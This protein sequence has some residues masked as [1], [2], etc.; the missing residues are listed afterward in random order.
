MRRRLYATGPSSLRGAVGICGAYI[1]SAALVELFSLFVTKRMLQIDIF[2]SGFLLVT[3]TIALT[4]LCLMLFAS[5]IS[6][7]LHKNGIISVNTALLL[8]FE[9]PV[10][11]I[12]F[13]RVRETW[14][15]AGTRN[16]ESHL[17]VMM[18]AFLMMNAA[19]FFMSK[20]V[21]NEMAEQ[22][23]ADA[24]HKAELE[25]IHFENVE[26]CRAELDKFK[27]EYDAML[28]RV[29]SLID[30]ERPDLAG[31]LLNELAKIIVM[32]T[33]EPDCQIP[34]GNALLGLKK[35][36]CE[37]EHIAFDVRL[38]LAETMSV[39]DMDLCIILGN[40]LDNAIRECKKAK[41]KPK[42]HI[43]G[44][45]VQGYL[46]LRCTNPVYSME[47]KE[48]EGTGYGLKILR[49]MASRYN[50]DFFARREGADFI[51]QISLH[52]T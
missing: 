30:E 40:L 25:S 47:R 46:V 51:S 7:S 28:A 19:A 22:A 29:Y 39:K 12:F 52:V 5:V 41:D 36:E 26:E 9:L 35:A 20:H 32:T 27:K 15:L 34:S 16:I 48:P 14:I 6:G 17:P 8:A 24:R 1:L 23:L 43:T 44:K 3:M 31:D 50:G 18:L 42:I 4:G 45:V 2:D 38:C 13:V 49:D 21:E 10:L 11:M 37:Q 33:E